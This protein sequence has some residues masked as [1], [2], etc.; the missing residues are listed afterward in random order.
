[1][2]ETQIMRITKKYI[3][4]LLNSL[5]FS[6]T[7][8]WGGIDQFNELPIF[9]TEDDGKQKFQQRGALLVHHK[10]PVALR[11]LVSVDEI[12]YQKV[13]YR[14]SGLQDKIEIDSP[15]RTLSP[16]VNNNV[17]FSIADLHM[18]Y[19]TDSSYSFSYN[20]ECDQK[21]EKTKVIELLKFLLNSSFYAIEDKAAFNDLIGDMKSKAPYLGSS[22]YKPIFQV[23]E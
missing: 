4:D 2:N 20:Y 16:M 19:E 5:C 8:S 18:C 22:H 21:E 6:N 12:D 10:L 1:M 11:L 23:I 9:A 7:V 3:T 17:D 15:K 13:C 14:I